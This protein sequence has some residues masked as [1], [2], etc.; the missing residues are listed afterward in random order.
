MSGRTLGSTLAEVELAIKECLQGK[1]IEFCSMVWFGDDPPSTCENGLGIAIYGD[2][3]NRTSDCSTFTYY[4]INVRA[5][6]CTPNP[7]TMQES[8]EEAC[9][10][11]DKLEAVYNAMVAWWTTVDGH[12]NIVKPDGFRAEG[13]ASNTC[14]DYYSSWVMQIN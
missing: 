8:T 1:N 3:S 5:S 2:I 6:I 7:E 14:T 9:A 13:G 11:Y 12:C 10:F 4:N